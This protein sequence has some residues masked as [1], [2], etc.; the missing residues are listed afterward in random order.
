MR[1]GRLLFL[2]LI[3]YPGQIAPNRSA[4]E[5]EAL[6]EEVTRVGH[7]VMRLRAFC[8]SAPHTGNKAG[9]TLG[10][11]ADEQRIA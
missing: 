2:F 6:D 7:Y 9:E 11:F 3:V 8:V 10:V 4:Q 5:L 1:I